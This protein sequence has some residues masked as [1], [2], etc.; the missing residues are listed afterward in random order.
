MPRP[1]KAIR[2]SQP[3]YLSTSL[4]S[5]IGFIPRRNMVGSAM[6]GYL[7]IDRILLEARLQPLKVLTYLPELVPEVSKATWNGL[8]LGCGPG[9]VRLK[10]MG[11]S[12]DG[13]TITEMPDGTEDIA[14]LFESLPQEVRGLENLLGQNF[15]MT[16]YSGMNAVECVPGVSGEGL[17]EIWPVDTLTTQ[18]RRDKV[19][20]YAALWQRYHNYNAASIGQ[21]YNGYI[22]LPMNRT[23]WSSMDNFPDDPYGRAPMAAALNP[24]LEMMAFM[25]DLLLAWHRVGMPK[26]DVGFDYE[27]HAEIAKNVLGIVEKTEIEKYVEDQFNHV[28]Q[29]FQSLQ[30]DDVFFHDI[31]SKVTATGSGGAWPNVKEIYDV[32][33][34]RLIIALKEMPTIMGVVEGNTDTWAG[35]DWQIYARGLESLVKKAASPLVQAAQLHLRLLGKPYTVHA[36]YEP[37]RANQR[38]V[39]AQAAQIEINN[40]LF[41]MAAGFITQTDASIEVTGTAP[42]VDVSIADIKILLGATQPS[43]STN[44]GGNGNTGSGAKQSGTKGP[45]KAS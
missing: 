45:S 17:K 10:A 2:V 31:K 6:N 38:M 33:R 41:K 37:V 22:P 28:V 11:K 12:K 44:Q 43:D 40:V 5:G 13:I 15:L 19:T 26:W 25:K 29:V 24:V 9:A 4:A 35:V 32:L 3:Q 23:F 14:N 30:A 20:G 16:M 1:A 7:S 39:D 42:V 21:Q 27:M 8:R 18:F 34:W 36:E